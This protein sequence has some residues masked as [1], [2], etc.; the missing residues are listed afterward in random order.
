MSL[1]MKMLKQ[2]ERCIR[3]EIII[4]GILLKAFFLLNK[5][6]I[7][8]IK[9]KKGIPSGQRNLKIGIMRPNKIDKWPPIPSSHILCKNWIKNPL[10]K[11]FNFL[12]CVGQFFMWHF[13]GNLFNFPWNIPLIHVYFIIHGNIK[14]KSQKHHEIYTFFILF[15]FMKHISMMF[16]K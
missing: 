16:L 9:N 14:L 7:L 15:Y 3:E 2:K 11:F 10:I 12:L 8:L 4:S 5:K 13:C 6:I 1:M